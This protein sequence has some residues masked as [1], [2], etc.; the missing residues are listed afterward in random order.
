[1]KGIAYKGYKKYALKVLQLNR[2][3]YPLLS[4]IL[5]VTSRCNSRCKGC[6]YWSKLNK[7]CN[8]LTL[9][10]IKNIS[11]NMGNVWQLQ[12]SGG[13]PFLRDDLEEICKTFVENNHTRLITLP[14]NGLNAEKIVGTTQN[15]LANCSCRLVISV[16]IDGTEQVNCKLRGVRGGFA[17]SLET[18]RTLGKLKKEYK[19]LGVLISTRITNA[20]IKNIPLLKKRLKDAGITEGHQIFSLRGKLKEKSIRPPTAG[21]Y[22]GLIRLLDKGASM[23]SKVRYNL[24]SQ[25]LDGGTWPFEC[26]AGKRI[27][28][29]ESDGDVRLCELLEPVGNL[30]KSNYDFHSVWNSKKAN[31]QRELI[32]SRKCSAG[33]THG[34]FI[35]PSLL[36]SPLQLAKLMLKS[37]IFSP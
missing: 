19:N 16:S 2:S 12:M 9:A 21:E 8:D 1:M 4:L 30:R 29:I 6:L 5:F 37:R 3:K 22:L 13:E 26:I 18:V 32:K 28:V 36:N 10:E 33:C 31:E 14:T 11:K 35:W 34:C 24:I 7:G 17:K 27:G 15:I 23:I 25:V 20:N